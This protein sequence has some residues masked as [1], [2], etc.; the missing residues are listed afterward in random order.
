MVLNLIA[1]VIRSKTLGRWFVVPD[2]IIRDPVVSHNT[3]NPPPGFN[4]TPEPSISVT[5]T[6]KP[7]PPPAAVI[8]TA[9]PTL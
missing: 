9:S 1:P 8:V 5:L 4:T 7:V 3:S 6:D 2:G